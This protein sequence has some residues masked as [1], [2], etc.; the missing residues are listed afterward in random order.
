MNFN[1]KNTTLEWCLRHGYLRFVESLDDFG[2]PQGWACP[3]CH[4][5][6]TDKI[7]KFDAI[8]ELRIN[9]AD[10]VFDPDPNIEIAALLRKMADKL[11]QGRF[12]D[13]VGVGKLI[14][15]EGNTVGYYSGG[16]HIE[17]GI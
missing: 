12:D 15:S 16:M 4:N 14:S 11:I 2:E 7:E 10:A 17:E 6:D 13:F 8:F 9:I 3:E 1:I 5:L